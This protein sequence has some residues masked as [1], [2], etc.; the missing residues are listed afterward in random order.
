MSEINDGE[1][2]AVF[3]ALRDY[4]AQVEP[5]FRAMLDQARSHRQATAR[6]VGPA[7][8]WVAA[9][10]C[11]VLAA[12]L[13]VATN[14]DRSNVRAAVTSIPTISGWQSPTAGLLDTQVR[15]LMAPA[16]VLSSVF[17]GVTTPLQLK[18]D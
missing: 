13:L 1:L 15:E 18:T 17:D 14:R 8:R 11:F 2:Q 3:T 6:S 7:L 12:A 16:P 9:A 10:A 5:A 4:D